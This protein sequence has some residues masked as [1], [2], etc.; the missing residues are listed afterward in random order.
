MNRHGMSVRVNII[1][2]FFVSLLI[3]IAR[4]PYGN[5]Q[6]CFAVQKVKQQ[7]WGA[8]PWKQY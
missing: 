2:Q 5:F 7:S 4:D 1:D 6:F 8:K 3:F